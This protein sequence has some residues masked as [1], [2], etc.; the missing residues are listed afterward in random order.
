[1]NKIRLQRFIHMRFKL[2]K[3]FI[4]FAASTLLAV[5]PP[6]ALADSPTRAA[7]AVCMEKSGGVTSAMLDCIATE[8]VWQDARLNKAY[9]AALAPLS[10]QRKKQLVT[11][12]RAWLAFQDA[13]CQFYA[14]PE[15]G[16]VAG[17]MANDC[18]LS[19]TASRA[20]ELEAFRD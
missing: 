18:L 10:A 19:T 7:H 16:S 6:A 1:M 17:V 2:Y 5:L 11:A 8:M 15:G 4:F 13:N 12:Q 3:K 9:K 20:L 14:D